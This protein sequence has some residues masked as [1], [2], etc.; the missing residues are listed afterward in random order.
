[1]RV[2]GLGRAYVRMRVAS[3]GTGDNV[4]ARDPFRR[5]VAFDLAGPLLAQPTCMLNFTWRKAAL[6]HLH[7]HLYVRWRTKA[8]HINWNDVTVRDLMPEDVQ[9]YLDYWFRSPIGQSLR[10]SLESFP[11]EAELLAKLEVSL[12]DPEQAPIQIVELD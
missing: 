4:R 8:M 5:L 9:A 12:L 11:S 6:G 2:T 3:C 1:M 7:A 10:A